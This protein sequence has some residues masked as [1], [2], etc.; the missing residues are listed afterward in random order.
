MSWVL[1]RDGEL[2]AEV[3]KVTTARTVQAV[4]RKNVN[5]GQ[6]VM[7][8]E[9]LSYKGLGIDYAHLSVNH[10]NN[11]AGWLSSFPFFVGGVI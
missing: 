7:T 5:A 8:D 4:K 10:S 11:L 2:R 9:H 6:I 1:K 3:V